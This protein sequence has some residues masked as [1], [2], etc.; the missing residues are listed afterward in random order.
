MSAPAR[1]RARPQAEAFEI[2]IEAAEIVSG[3]S[4]DLEELLRA[5][6]D[7]VGKVVDYQVFA[8][9]LRT[10][11]G[12]ALRIRS[13]VGYRS[14]VV[15]DL[16]VEL[17]KGITGVA[18]QQQKTLVVED[19]RRDPRYLHTVDGVRSEI[20]VPLVARGELVGVID[21]QSTEPGAFDEQ[22]KNLLELIGS[23]F[24]LAIEAARL[25]RATLSRNRVLATLSRVAQEFS[26]IL[27]LDELLTKVSHLVRRQ[28]PYDAFSILLLE[29]ESQI[30]KHYFGVRFDEH[31]Q[32]SNMPLG[33]G[34]V[35]VAAQDAETV[36]VPD[37]SRDER[38]IPMVEG[39]RS[40]VAVPLLLKDEVIGVLD[41]ECEQVNAF[42]REHEWLL[43]LLAPQVAI[44]IE[45]AR[46]YEQVET[47]QARLERDLRAARELQR[48]LLPTAPPRVEGIEV[49]ARN[50][51]A[52]EVSGDIYDFFLLDGG[53]LGVFIGDVSGKGAPAALY[54]ALVSG[55]MRELADNRYL[56][57]RLL[58][59]LNRALLSRKIEAR[60][61][62]ALY[63]EWNP[64]KHEFRL[65]NA[66]LPRPLLYSRGSVTP[67]DV[68]GIP[69]GLIGVSAYEDLTLALEPGDTIVFASDGITESENAALEQ[70]GDREL[71]K[72]VERHAEES[73]TRLLDAVFESV[74][75]FTDAALAAD[76]RTVIVVKKAVDGG[77]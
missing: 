38:Y 70:F 37:T 10:A 62:T 12:Q 42:T 57:S 61:L 44:A 64:A 6:R 43:S 46:L 28:I 56:P 25:H 30:L 35:G 52:T 20:A 77:P 54:G 2:L 8:V 34:I 50:D 14:E 51:S 41:L 18:A 27:N 15:R 40:E 3:H 31:I 55:L 67:L 36:L 29:K 48:H 76:D 9:L 4:L 71:A 5:L 49:A 11:D 73:P 26:H 63:A 53:G 74:N 1:L 33:Q 17:G 24:S 68:S 60:Y 69:L 16:R 7:L 19:V 45:N 65:A 32:W 59:E 23:R 21:L 72:V 39:I 22:G 13:S 58:V 75:V 47:N 66:G